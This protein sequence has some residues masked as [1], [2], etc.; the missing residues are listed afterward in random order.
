MH[1]GRITQERIITEQPATKFH[2]TTLVAHDVA[3]GKGMRQGEG[4]CTWLAM[5]ATGM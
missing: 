2:R 3:S 1:V 5:G 4:G